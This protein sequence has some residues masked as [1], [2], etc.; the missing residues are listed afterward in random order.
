MQIYFNDTHD[1]ENML[2]T[3]FKKP[4]YDPSKPGDYLKARRVVLKEVKA[5]LTDEDRK[6]LDDFH[7]RHC[8]RHRSSGGEHDSESDAEGDED[9]ELDEEEREKAKEAKEAKEH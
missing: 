9:E 5:S 4:I 6:E 8:S 2:I 3:E 1:I 7:E